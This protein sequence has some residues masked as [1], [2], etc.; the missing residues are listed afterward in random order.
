[1]S[2]LAIQLE[3]LQVREIIS[4]GINMG[5][6]AKLQR[7][8]E[9]RPSESISKDPKGWW[10]YAI[11]AVLLQIRIDRKKHLSLRQISLRHRDKL[12]YTELWKSKLVSSATLVNQLQQVI[13]FAYKSV[14]ASDFLLK[15][16]LC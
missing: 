12:V 3:D 13:I 10:R 5:S 15:Q 1:M 9:F 14:G 4:V 2:E 11:N 7:F 6:F 16:L 8:S